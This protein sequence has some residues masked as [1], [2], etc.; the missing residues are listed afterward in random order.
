MCTAA[1]SGH[2]QGYRNY[3]AARIRKITSI[4]SC[5]AEDSRRIPPISVSL[6]FISL[7]AFRVCY[8]CL[9]DMSLISFF[10]CRSR[11][12]PVP[13]RG[14]RVKQR[15]MQTRNWFQYYRKNPHFS[16][17]LFSV[18]CNLRLT[19]K[20]FLFFRD[21]TLTSINLS[22][23][24]HHCAMHDFSPVGFGAWIRILHSLQNFT[25]SF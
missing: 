18:A 12:Y 4:G 20:H 17:I 13:H 9:E 19:V 21:S 23:F 10:F 24:P 7:I 11:S 16:Y 25:L 22:A 8:R 15:A 3:T 6:V 2:V 5:V 14:E 1:L